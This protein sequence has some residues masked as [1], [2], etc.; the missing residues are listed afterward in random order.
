M[1]KDNS[2]KV[3][4]YGNYTRNGLIGV[5]TVL[6]ASIAITALLVYAGYDVWSRFNSTGKYKVE[7]EETTA[8]GENYLN[9][10]SKDNIGKQVS[11][12]GFMNTALSEDSTAA[13]LMPAPFLTDKDITSGE[14]TCLTLI[15]KE[16]ETL[17]YSEYAISATGKL[18]KDTDGNWVLTNVE[19]KTF[20]DGEQGTIEQFN[21]LMYM[22]YAKQVNSIMSEIYYMINDGTEGSG[23]YTDIEST[24]SAL[25]QQYGDIEFMHQAAHIAGAAREF[26]DIVDEE[27]HNGTINEHKD[28]LNKQAEEIYNNFYNHLMQVKLI[29]DK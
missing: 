12:V 22:G 11:V 24:I 3:R 7:V 26:I 8:G 4:V 1:D 15:A 2:G 18:D 17:A 10:L 13:W 16:N 19:I 9:M 23:N 29:K 20:G 14:Y 21:Q 25:E 28:D 5:T 27:L 6:I